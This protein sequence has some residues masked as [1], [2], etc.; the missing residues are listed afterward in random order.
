MKTIA[1]SWLQ[2]TGKSTLIRSQNEK[3]VKIL[4]E[5]ARDVLAKYPW[6]SMQD[7][8]DII[9]R[10]ESERKIEIEYLKANSRDIHTLFVDRT[11]ID[12]WIYAMRNQ[13][14]WIIES[15]NPAIYDPKLYDEVIYMN[16]SIWP[17]KG[18][19]EQYEW[20]EFKAMFDK[21][22]LHCYPNAHVFDNYLVNSQ[23][24]NDLISNLTDVETTTSNK[25]EQ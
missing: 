16:K 4:W 17:S 20:E 9:H 19:Y 13:D 23:Q 25:S 18:K 12:N 7:F 11:S 3:W 22:M 5:T 21:Y 1:I 8:Q 14:L 6:I 2:N 10:R 24:I 15:I